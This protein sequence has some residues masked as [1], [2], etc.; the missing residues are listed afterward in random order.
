VL[1]L[2][3]WVLLNNADF[4]ERGWLIAKPGFTIQ[5]PKDELQQVLKRP[6]LGVTIGKI[7]D[8]ATIRDP[9]SAELY[10]LQPKHYTLTQKFLARISEGYKFSNK[11]YPGQMVVPISWCENR[12]EEFEGLFAINWTRSSTLRA[13]EALRTFWLADGFAP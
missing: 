5:G 7:V 6:P 2:A 4:D 12:P 3:E 13:R 1:L 11:I 8:V 10:T 9:K